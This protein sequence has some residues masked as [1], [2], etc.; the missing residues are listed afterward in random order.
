MTSIKI[1]AIELFHI[2]IPFAV[3]YE[4]SKVYGT[5]TD[6]EAVIVKV[7][8]DAGIV[9]LGEADPMNPFTEETPGTVMTIL[10]DTI[11]PLL[12]GEDPTRVAALEARLD[13]S[14]HGHVVA[15]GAINMALCDIWGKAHALPAHVLLGGL[16]HAQ[17]PLFGAIGSGTP[18]EDARALEAL[19]QQGFGTVMIK[20]GALPID[21]EV[22]RMERAAKQFGRRITL[23]ADA[24]QGWS[25]NEAL[26]F[27]DGIRGVEPYVL[28]QPIT[29]HDFT[30]LKRIRERASCMLSADESLFTLQDAVRLIQSSSVDV[31]SIKVS[32]NGGLMKSSMIARLAEAFGIKCLMNSM[33]EFGISQAASLQVGCTLN[34]ILDCGHAYM[35]VLRMADDITDFRDHIT[36]AVVTV[37]NAPGL[38]V[39][40]ADDKLKQYTRE[41]RK[42]EN[43]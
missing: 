39:A 6:A 13:R 22:E 14:V 38:G 40:L 43:T 34:N 17:L 32:K 11:G 9:G 19:I 29:S 33:L 10:R 23:I 4:L 21:Q 2:S 30:G 42:I 15:R 16:V 27:V 41:H 3:P 12:L 8:T 31:F 28:E 1:T 37:P 24:N 25:L 20:M 35:S 26:R 36:D 18:E 7:H 5:L